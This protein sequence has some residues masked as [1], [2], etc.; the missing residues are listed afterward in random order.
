[1]WNLC[2]KFLQVDREEKAKSALHAAD[3]RNIIYY[4]LYVLGMFLDPPNAIAYT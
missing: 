4:R 3:T 2:E 1:M